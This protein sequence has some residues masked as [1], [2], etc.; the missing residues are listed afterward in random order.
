[1]RGVSIRDRALLIHRFSTALIARMM[2]H[3][4][5]NTSMHLQ[6]YQEKASATYVMCKIR[7]WQKKTVSSEITRFSGPSTRSTYSILGRFRVLG[8]LFERGF[9]FLVTING[10]P[11][12]REGLL[13][14]GG[15][16]SSVYGIYYLLS[17]KTTHADGTRCAGVEM[18]SRCWK[19]LE[20]SVHILF[21]LFRIQSRILPQ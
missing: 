12:N 11:S 19:S 16:Y 9:Y 5:K 10:R 8:T 21:H 2:T 3:V 1:M 4:S 6:L 7:Y 20:Y 13:L 17:C 18:T 14:E 15:F